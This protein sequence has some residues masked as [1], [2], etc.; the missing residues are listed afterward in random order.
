[1]WVSIVPDLLTVPTAELAIG[2]MLSLGRSIVA[3]DNKI[4]SS[5][6]SG[7]RPNFYGAGLAN[8]TV[9]ILG[10][11]CVGRAI[12]G[13][14][15]GFQSRILALDEVDTQPPQSLAN[16]VTMTNRDDLLAE[17]DFL[18][19]ALP[20]TAQTLHILDR[21]TI[22]RVKPG[23]RIINP[24]RG[25]LVDEAAIADAIEA[26]HLAGYAAD[27]FECED[28]ARESQAKRNRVAA[29]QVGRSHGVD[30]RILGLLLQACVRK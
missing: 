22:A 2:L 23:A 28:W 25:S 20:L 9:G 30:P 18:I 27:V 14:L 19:L 29:S 26:G 11:G 24:A 6:I 3:A 5:G 7:W 10:F 13:R 4:R 21:D 17:T 12:A 16:H 15:V 1:V 8:S